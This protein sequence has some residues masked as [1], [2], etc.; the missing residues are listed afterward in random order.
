MKELYG[1]IATLDAEVRGP[2]VSRLIDEEAPTL[3]PIAPDAMVREAGWN[4]RSMDAVLNRVQEARQALLDQLR[5]LPLAAWARTA[6]LEDETLTLFDLVHGITQADAERLRDL[7]Y[8][9]HGAHL[10]DG[11]E[12]L[13]T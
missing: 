10:S 2:R 5:A 3:E 12:P 9:L 7:G 13:P 8:R 4:D 6:T 11:D 1:A